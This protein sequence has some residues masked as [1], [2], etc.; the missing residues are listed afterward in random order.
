MAI[1]LRSQEAHASSS[2]SSSSS[3]ISCHPCYSY[4]VF[5]SF[6]GEDTRRSFTDHLYAALTQAGIRTFRDDDEMERGKLL[7]VELKKAICESAISIIVFSTN[8][9]S[10]KWCLDEVLT[11]IEENERL[12]SKHEVVPVFYNIEPSDVRNQTGSFENAFSRYDDIIETES[13]HQNKIQWSEKVNAWRASLKKAGSLTGMVLANGHEAKFIRQIVRVV[14][15]KLGYKLLYMEDRLVGIKKN[16]GEIELWLQDPSPDAVFLVLHGMGGIGKT[17]ISKCIYNSN[18]HEYDVSCFLADIGETS[19]HHNGLIRLQS[20]L[21]ST[22]YRSKK[23]EVIWTLD[24]GTRKIRD[25]ICSKK[26]LLILDNVT[27]RQ[28]LTALL[29]PQHLYPGSKVIITTRHQW[30]L[31]VFKI[32]P[33][34]HSIKELDHNE[35]IELFCL[36]AFHK[37]KPI[38]PYAVES[39]LVVHHC[40]GLPLALKILGSSLH[41]KNIDVWKDEIR[42]LEAIPNSE[43]QKIL[44]LS[45]ESIEDSND[46]DVFLHIACF[47]VGEDKE[48]IEMGHEIVRQQSRKDPGK[49][50]RLWRHEDSFIVLKDNEATETVSDGSGDTYATDTTFKESLVAAGAGLSLVDYVVILPQVNTYGWVW[51]ILL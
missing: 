23:E 11:I 46:K 32:C 48:Y 3:S 38:E 2:S 7:E 13:D 51:A 30:L 50:S 42:K 35:S 19:S 28:Q 12:S 40:R 21:L 49:R 39:E 18:S 1:V 34:L 8:Y 43:I 33:K 5:L 24:E 4:D 31:D 9:A 44:K 25:A 6:R 27:T 29:G 37:D 26:I 14:R 15:K 10:S 47:F 17:T 16:V 41:G 45:Y 22:I 36:Y 20:Q